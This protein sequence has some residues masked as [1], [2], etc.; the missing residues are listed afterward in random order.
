MNRPLNKVAAE[1]DVAF[2]DIK[3]NQSP[4]PGYVTHCRPYIDAMLTMK[5]FRDFYGI[6]IG[7]DVGLRFLSNAQAWRGDTARRLKAEIKQLLEEAN[8]HNSR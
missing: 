7:S 5:S 3:R 6:D 4:T 2:R 1:I 8:A